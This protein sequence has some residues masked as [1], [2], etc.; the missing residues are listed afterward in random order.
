[1][2]GRSEFCSHLARL[3]LSQPDLA[4]A[5]LWFYNESGLYTDRRAPDLAKDLHEE[6]F[7]KPNVTYLRKQLTIH[8][9]VIQGHKK[10]S[11]KIGRAYYDPLAHEYGDFIKR[12]KVIVSDAILP[13]E[14]FADT[15]RGYLINLCEQIN[16]S[17]NFGFYDC[18]AVICR[19]LMETLIIEVYVVACRTSHIEDAKNKF[20]PLEKLIDIVSSDS[21]VHLNRNSPSIFTKV[22]K[23]GDTA[24]H[25][26]THVT[27]P[28]EVNDLKDDYRRVIQ[29]LLTLSKLK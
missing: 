28:I 18:C 22:K 17:H 7:T 15:G 29:E 11:F 23:L 13:S 26:R 25:H 24:A 12:E 21:Q 27:D 19:R 8:K 14:W 4:V 20:K 1:M 6:G 3:D 5:L 2:N 16:G 9:K 10:D